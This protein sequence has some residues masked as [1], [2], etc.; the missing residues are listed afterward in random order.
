MLKKDIFISEFDL[1]THLIDSLDDYYHT[2]TFYEVFYVINGEIDHYLN[3]TVRTLKTGDTVFLRPNDLHCFLRKPDQLAS[4]H[5]DI[6]ITEKQWA[7]ACDYLHPET[8]NSLNKLPAP[9]SCQLNAEAMLRLENKLVKLSSTNNDLSRTMQ[10]NNVCI[11]LLSLYVENLAQ[12]SIHHSALINQIISKM[13]RPD[14]FKAGIPKILSLFPTY[15]QNYLCRLFK[16]HTGMTMTDYLNNIRINYAVMLLQTQ[17]LS[18]QQIAFEC[19]FNNIS[20]FNRVFKD[21]YKMS[22]SQFKKRS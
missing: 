15:S 12:D 3:G 18:I 11:D 14:N 22:P 5:R 9:F 4:R 1:Q 6:M 21:H 19:G 10:I 13:H 8:F 17:N 16:Q 20:Y 7:K 2:H